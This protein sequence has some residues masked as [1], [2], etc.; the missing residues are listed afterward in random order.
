MTTYSYQITFDDSEIIAVK[1]A[2]EF[3]LSDDAQKIF[4]ENK[5]LKFVNYYHGIKKAL[6]ANKLYGGIDMISTSSLCE[7][8][9]KLK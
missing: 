5:D 1:S 6:N 7:R 3:Y 9:V 8:V 4:E 2:L